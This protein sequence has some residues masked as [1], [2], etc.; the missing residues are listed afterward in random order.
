MLKYEEVK[1]SFDGFT[2][3]EINPEVSAEIRDKVKA[4]NP[5]MGTSG[6]LIAVTCALFIHRLE[7]WPYAEECN[8]VNKREFFRGFS[9]K[10]TQVLSE[11]ETQI[12]EKREE[13][14]GNLLGGA[15]GT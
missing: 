2:V 4:D 10:A 6:Y 5:E 14:L 3:S 7:S 12:K 11:A 15:T 9:E 13:L 1:V 8:D